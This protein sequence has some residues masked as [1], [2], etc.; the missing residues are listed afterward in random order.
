MSVYSLLFG[1]SCFYVGD[2]KDGFGEI[3]K[4]DWDC[5]L[6]TNEVNVYKVKHYRKKLE[7]DSSI[8]I[9]AAPNDAD[10]QVETVKIRDAVYIP[11]YLMKLVLD[12]DLSPR[13][14]FLLLESTID[15]DKPKCCNGILDFCRVVGT[16][17]NDRS[18]KLVVAEDKAGTLASVSIN[19]AL[20]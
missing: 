2:V 19:R 10:A 4:F 9:F 13:E 3:A 1:H 6:P 17:A 18:T 20:Q 8:E 16:L 11:Y 5:L 12:K 14:V 7:D 15:A